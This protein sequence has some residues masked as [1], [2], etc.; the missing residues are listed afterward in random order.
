[1]TPDER[2][3]EDARDRFVALVENSEEFVA[4]AELNGTVLYVNAA[5]RRLVGLELDDD[6]T[7]TRMP[8]Y[9]PR[10]RIADAA[11][12]LA[13][14]LRDGRWSGEFE[15]RHFKTGER[16]PVYCNA[17]VLVSPTGRRTLAQVTRD[18]R[19]SKAVEAEQ[20]AAQS[21]LALRERQYRELADA[22]PQIVWSMDV[23]GTPDYYNRRWYAYTGIGSGE[24]PRWER[25][26]HPDDRVALREL[27]YRGDGTV[28]PS[29]AE[30][31]LRAAAGNYRWH[32]VTAQAV[33][34]DAGEVA[35]WIGI[36]SDIEERRRADERQRFL[37]DVS[38][39]LAES[40]DLDVTLR[41]ILELLVPAY[42]DMA[43]VLLAGE[44]GLP[45]APVAARHAQPAEDARLLERLG[46]AGNDGE[47]AAAL[48][49]AG[50]TSRI[51]VPLVADGAPLGTLH[52][53]RVAPRP[54]FRDGDV[55]TFAEAGARTAAAIVNAR[56]YEREHRVADALQRASLPA[57][58]PSTAEVLFSGHYV[59]G[60]SDAL[61]GGDWYDA[62]RLEDGRFVISIGDVAGSGLAAA[63]IMGNVRQIVRGVAQ[64]Y[65]D[66]ALMLDAAD[67]ALR[68]EHPERFV[69]AFVAVYDP[70]TS[71]LT[72]ASAGHPPA[73]LV[74]DGRATALRGEG[75]PLGLRDSAQPPPAT[76]S[77][78]RPSHAVFYTD[79]LIESTRDIVDGQRL[80]VAALEEGAAA[81]SSD[82]SGTLV[83]RLLRAGA[84]DDVAV[85]VVSFPGEGTAA[86]R[87]RWPIDARDAGATGAARQALMA[88]LA[89]R[90][91][92]SEALH[93]CELI[94]AELVG[95]VV[96][97]TPG[98]AEIVL[99]LSLRYAVL[100]VVDGGSGFRH[101]ARLPAD[102]MSELG[103]G[104]FL[105]NAL[106][107]DFTVMAHAGGGS[108][109]I[110]TLPV[111]GAQRPA[112]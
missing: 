15:Y 84:Q 44:N 61:I 87:I 102:P 12:L 53:A 101:I 33:R 74:A 60:A 21:A 18:L 62:V 13:D 45:R 56:L 73:Y 29:P 37:S 31:R 4:M 30:V 70:V 40:L 80:L 8:D 36:A 103:R 88:R 48:S 34:D 108:H 19:A 83:R 2:R 64:I 47:I 26:V 32:L 49:A 109:A 65:A 10:D 112:S 92:S 17:F 67:R 86:E 27:W 22:I 42:A 39:R 106:A 59:P 51:A 6:V 85:L 7:A 89:A 107:R 110:V 79:G 90:A 35:K 68:L 81:G 98:P 111:R 38:R 58:L 77:V 82:S 72:F 14:T 71:N 94:L 104:L 9:L 25:A 43:V 24:V 63:V 105:I 100:H 91:S 78:S 96:R 97:H 57:S 95:N 3:L 46:D 69:T 23:R 75:L 1:M 55:D 11:A 93:A 52:V 50:A 16:L 28:F 5:G 20:R 99:D 41:V 66:P 76:V 54:A